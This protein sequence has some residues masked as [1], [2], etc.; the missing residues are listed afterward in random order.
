MR[1]RF[2]SGTAA[3]APAPGTRSHRLARQA[4]DLQR[5]FNFP[6]NLSSAANTPTPRRRRLPSSNSPCRVPHSLLLLFYVVSH[7]AHVDSRATATVPTAR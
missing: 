2:L 4:E 7:R 3:P 1:Q 6:L 5:P